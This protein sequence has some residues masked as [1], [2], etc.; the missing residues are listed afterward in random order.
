MSATIR[1]FGDANEA[2]R[3]PPSSPAKTPPKSSSGS[4][5]KTPPS[6][7][8]SLF[9]LFKATDSCLKDGGEDSMA[10]LRAR[11]TNFLTTYP[12][13]SSKQEDPDDA[14]AVGR[15]DESLLHLLFNLSELPTSPDVVRLR[16]QLR[17]L[18]TV[19]R[20]LL[21]EFNSCVE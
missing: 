15:I 5:Q 13:S 14:D 16:D 12:S 2:Y 20:N 6:M 3:T 21:A 11:V 9:H 4:P 8:T 17:P 10:I 7:K 1:G 19:R 18:V